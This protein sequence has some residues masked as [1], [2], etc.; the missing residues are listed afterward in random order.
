[1]NRLRLPV[2]AARAAAGNDAAPLRLA[3]FSPLPPARSGIADYSEEL[4]PYLTQR[5]SLTLFVARP[6]EVDPALQARYD[7][8]PLSVYPNARWHYDLPLYQMGNSIHHEA[9][10]QMMR[11]FPGIVVL[12][13]YVLHHFLAHRTAGRGDPAAY[14]RELAYNLGREGIDRAWALRHGALDNDLATLPLNRRVLDLSLGVL[15]HSEYVR[16]RLAATHSRRPIIAVPAPITS[17]AARPR[18]DRL[19]WPADAIV[20]ASFGQMTASKCLDRALRAFAALRVKEPR[21]RYLLVGAP[22]EDSDLTAL[23]GALNLEE[24]VFLAGHAPGLQAFLDWLVTADVVIN[25][26][27]PTLGETSAAALRAL[28]AG[29]PLI[30]YD[31]GWYSELPDDVAV[32]IPPLDDAALLAALEDLAL[33]PRRREALAAAA[34][35]YAGR[36]HHPQQTAR[37]YVA[38]IRQ[39]I[40]DVTGLCGDA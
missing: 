22:M 38:G 15:V 7:V 18:R 21:L 32:K 28:A 23:I 16:S 5:C 14:G 29:R 35:T 27:H 13:D 40:R 39:I 6:E 3:Y 20:F 8:R 10:F 26:R 19:P 31:H 4:L 24:S 30:V 33:H 2:P 36:A 1:V 37:A 9:L 25:L 11:R 17:P 12:H 34:R